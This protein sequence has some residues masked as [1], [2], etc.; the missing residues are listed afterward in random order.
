MTPT[1]HGVLCLGWDVHH[2]SIDCLVAPASVTLRE[3]CKGQVGQRP[4]TFI[5]RPA[6]QVFL[7]EREMAAAVAVVNEGCC[8]LVRDDI[9]LMIVSTKSQSKGDQSP[10][11]HAQVILQLTRS[12]IRT[13]VP[14]V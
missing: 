3:M 11:H 4:G 8:F 10:T 12:G 1:W 2:K 6:W 14:Q 9:S 5:G 7:D 13:P